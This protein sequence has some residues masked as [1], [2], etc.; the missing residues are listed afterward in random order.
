MRTARLV[1]AAILV[2]ASLAGCSAA[3]FTPRQHKAALF[4]DKAGWSSRLID[5]GAFD[6]LS[7]AS[8]SARTAESLT[9]YI[10]G[11]GLAFLDRV[12][13]SPD[14]TPD[15]P[16]AL[17]LALAAPQRPAVWLA[18]PC[19]YVMA[20]HPRNCGPG[21]WTDRRYAPEVVEGM[22]R[23]LDALKVA[24]GAR[25]LVLVGYSGGGALA[26]LL[27]ARRS[28]VTGIVTIA[29]N[30]DLGDWTHRHQLAPLAG[31]LDPAAF[32]DRVAQ[33]PQVHFVGSD[34]GVVPP[35][36]VRA[37]LSHLSRSNRASLIEIPGYDHACCWVDGWPQLIKRREM[38][39][40]GVWE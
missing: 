39:A 29:A 25:R 23:A 35:D 12:T 17:R 5:A 26:V 16:I 33:L 8:P 11:D 36:V 31:S 27:A 32:A 1:C 4:A 20:E 7:Y 21:L 3:Y 37:Y 30:L 13:V 15:D 18:R 28:D 22:D 19:Q 24:S 14:P 40:L 2:A 9:V 34:D 10:E 38:T 6:L